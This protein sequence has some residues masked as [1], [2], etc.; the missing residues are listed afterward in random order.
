LEGQPSFWLERLLGK[1]LR[2]L[3]FSHL[4]QLVLGLGQILVK[5][6]GLKPFRGKLGRCK[7]RWLSN[8]V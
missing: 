1:G 3:V 6:W 5:I 2:E 8:R 4:G 7:Q